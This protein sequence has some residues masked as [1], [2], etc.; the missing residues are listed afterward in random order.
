ML[1]GDIG[2]YAAIFYYQ[3]RGLYFIIV[4][5]YMSIKNL[6][7]DFFLALKILI[8]ICMYV[9]FRISPSKLNF[10]SFYFSLQMFFKF[11]NLFIWRCVLF[12]V[13]LT[14]NFKLTIVYNK[15]L[16]LREQWQNLS[17]LL[18]KKKLSS[19]IISWKFK[20]KNS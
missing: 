12:E 4:R 13:C 7:K 20:K 1:L 9:Y 14:C 5:S 8:Y 10:F 18:K 17:T 11:L 19:S 3:E 16:Q 6:I 2:K 15:H